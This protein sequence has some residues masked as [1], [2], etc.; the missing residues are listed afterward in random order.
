MCEL[1][2]VLERH[3]VDEGLLDTIMD[4]VGRWELEP[5]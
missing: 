1:C 3:R 2:A 4:M 5:K